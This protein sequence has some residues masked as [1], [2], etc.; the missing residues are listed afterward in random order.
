M[1]E[2]LGLGPCGPV[3]ARNPVPPV[4]TDR[5][6]YRGKDLWTDIHRTLMNA[7]KVIYICGWSVWA[8]PRRRALQGCLGSR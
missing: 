4:P 7:K 2:V 8:R 6:E 5:G 3:P 1:L